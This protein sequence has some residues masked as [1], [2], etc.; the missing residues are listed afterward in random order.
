[1]ELFNIFQKSNDDGGEQGVIKEPPHSPE[2]SEEQR[3]Q[4]MQ[5]MEEL[6]EQRTS[7]PA[8]FEKTMESLGLGSLNGSEGMTGD[9]L[10][11]HENKI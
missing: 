2:L 8:A 3:L 1:M 11:T 5:F 9:D 10:S 4:V 6:M 7:D